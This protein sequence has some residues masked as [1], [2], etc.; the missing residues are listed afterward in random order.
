MLSINFKRALDNIEIRHC[1]QPLRA[2]VS[3]G[4]VL[5]MKE[6]RSPKGRDK[7]LKEK[8]FIF[9]TIKDKEWIDWTKR[10]FFKIFNESLDVQTRLNELNKISF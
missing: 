8:I 10:L 9:Y 2:V 3:D 7:E 6:I 4:K 1:E 5:R